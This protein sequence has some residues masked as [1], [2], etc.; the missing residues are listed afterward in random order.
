MAVAAMLKT[1]VLGHRAAMGDAL[2]ALQR[3]GA[4]DVVATE[5][6]LESQEIAPE[7]VR[8]LHVE[9]RLAEAI[10]IRDFLGRHHTSETPF[11]TFVAEKV[12]LTPERFFALEYDQ[13]QHRVYR[14]CEGIA[15]R[16]ASGGRERDRFTALIR[17][18]EPWLS[19]RLQ[20]GQ[21]TGTEHT[22][23][24]TG[25]VPAS[26]AADI[27]AR[28]REEV[29]EVTVEELGPKGDRQAWVVIATCDQVSEVRA[30][31]GATDFIEVAFPGLEDYPAEEA[32]DARERITEIEAAEVRLIERATELAVKHYHDAVALVQALESDRDAI[33]LHRDIVGTERA[34][35][36]TGWVRE[37]SASKVTEALAPFGDSIDLSFEAPGEDDEPPVALDNPAWL[38]PFEILTDLYGRPVYR[39]A[40]PT[41]LLAPFFLL[42]F[43]L[44][45]GDVGY[46]AMLIGG[47][48]LVKHRLD[49]TAGVKRFMDLLMMGGALS[50]VVGVLLGSYLALPVESLPAPLRAMQ[51]LDPIEDIQQ[52][53]LVAL[54][55]G[56]IQV[57]FGVFVAA[58]A[59]FKRGD[60]ESAI[61]DQLSIVFLFVML[62]VTAV[63]GV[64]GNGG[65][66]R[67]SLVIGVVGAMVMQG[68]AVQAALR[69]EGIASWD[70]MFGLAWAAVFVGG[71]VA[72]GVTG[73]MAALWA[74]LGISAAGLFASKAVRRGVVGVLSGAYN[75]Y[76]L[77]GFVGDVLSY[78]RLPALGLSG[79]LVGSVFNI[80]TELVWS[81]ASPLFAKGG[82]SLVGGALIAVM[83]IAVF[84]VGHVFNVVINLLGAFVHPT[85]L[86]FVEFFSKFYEAGGRPFSPF[87]FRTDGIVLDAGVAGEEGGRV[88]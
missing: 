56:L 32:A 79:S 88:S 7:D 26:T 75:V 22:A 39:Q 71:V 50:M 76:G 20:I 40:D 59:A 67:A 8:R 62:G 81:G 55:I 64:T 25:T 74:A 53:L 6:D 17:E 9:E 57:F 61:F 13:H 48:W 84:A 30:V 63:A 44:C 1:T 35:I 45:I 38:K 3:S 60:A 16:I 78:L 14:E 27:R 52:F 23:L 58:W 65:L 24:F 85:R 73:A 31:L 29:A 69:T 12:H 54:V 83:A 41:P 28:L 68:R 2:E 15:D 86:Q 33:L 72:Y 19:F 77:T 43:A 34:F 21:W 49:V 82:F 70:R 47:A 36:L 5:L 51:V 18:L 46:G 87:G 42:F 11:S 10:F 37:S 4:L 66:V 80:L